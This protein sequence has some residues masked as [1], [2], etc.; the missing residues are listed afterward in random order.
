MTHLKLNTTDPNT[1]TIGTGTITVG[2]TSMIIHSPAV[3]N[4][5]MIFITPTTLI[6][7][8]II[9]NRKMSGEGFEVSI[10]TPMPNAVEFQWMIVN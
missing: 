10:A 8:P 3:T 9:V 5:S 4:T 7:K 6:D 1:T 2:S